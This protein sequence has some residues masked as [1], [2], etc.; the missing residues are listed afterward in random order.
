MAGPEGG[1]PPA[2]APRPESDVQHQAEGAEPQTQS[3]APD[4]RGLLTRYLD[5]FPRHGNDSTRGFALPR[6]EKIDELLRR[7]VVDS[8][9]VAEELRASLRGHFE[10]GPRATPDIER[11]MRPHRGRSWPRRRSTRC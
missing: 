2:A 8:E 11:W 9:D 10:V 5:T 1:Q 6:S 4:L 7:Y 3:A